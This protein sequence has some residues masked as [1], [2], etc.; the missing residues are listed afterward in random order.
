[1]GDRAAQA[2]RRPRRRC[3]SGAITRSTNHIDEQSAKRSSSVTAKVAFCRSSSSTAGCVSRVGRSKARERAVEPPLPAVRARERVGRRTV[4]G[5]ERGQRAQALAL[6]RRASSGQVSAE[7]GRRRVQR[8]TS[9]GAKRPRVSSQN[10]LGSRGRAVV[11]RGLADEV[12]PP[13]RPRAGRVEEVAVARDRVGA[14]QAAGARRA[15]ELGLLL[16]VEERRVLRAARQAA[17]LEP[18][19]EDDLEAARARAQQVEHRD[20][21]GLAAR[22]EPDRGVG[23]RE[24]TSSRVGLAA[25]VA[26]ALELGDELRRGLVRAQVEPR[27]LVRRRR[28]EP[29]GRAQHRARELP[30]RVERVGRAADGVE[31]RQ[32]LAAQLRHLLLDPLRLGHAAAAQP[33]L[34]EVDVLAREPRVRRAQEGEEVA[35]LAAEPREAEQREQ[36]LAERRLVEPQPALRARTGRR[37]SRRPSRAARASARATGRRSRSRPPACRRGAAR[38]SPRRRARACRGCRRPRGSGA[39][40][41]ARAPGAARR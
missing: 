39:R 35:P 29:V 13:R 15:L 21:A 38:G 18:E 3:S 23:E 34:E 17:L 32:R 8:A 36:R 4:G 22:A 26:P 25:E 9:S 20:A 41:R 30:D 10:G 37:A 2:R 7:S 12:E 33:A 28:V 16:L 24:T 6:A 5:R 27:G 11:G 19:H 14:Q 31:E 40:R 1:M